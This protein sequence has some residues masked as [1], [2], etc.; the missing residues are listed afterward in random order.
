MAVSVCSFVSRTSVPALFGL[1]KLK[2]VR[3][4]SGAALQLCPTCIQTSS[5]SRT[6]PGLAATVTKNVVNY[7]I[8]FPVY[9]NARKTLLARKVERERASRGG[10]EL[11][12]TAEAIKLDF[13]ETLACGAAAGAAS[14]AFSHPVDVVKAQ[15][16]SLHAH[17]FNGSSLA[18]LR[19]L[20][21]TQRFR[22]IYAGTRNHE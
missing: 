13:V 22:G 7:S 18:C 16:M 1:G 17:K 9:L 3:S 20:W 21:E 8:R 15:M 6:C 12:A 4:A 5:D 19:W 2:T 11:P 14:C 10:G